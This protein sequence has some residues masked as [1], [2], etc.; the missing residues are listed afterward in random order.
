MNLKNKMFFQ[1]QKTLA[2][3]TYKTIDLY[4]FVK[5]RQF[6][7]QI[8]HDVNSKFRNIN[9]DDYEDD[10]EE[11]LFKKNLNN[12]ESSRE[13][14]NVSDVKFRSD[15]FKSNAN[16]QNLNNREMSQV[17]EFDQ[18]NAFTSYNCDK[19][20]YIA[21]MCRVFRNMNF[22]NFVRKIDEDQTQKKISKR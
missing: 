6:I 11:S 2:L 4:E 9:R 17:L 12:Q 22:K 10:Y 16:N 14:L 1:L 15:T 3:N 13:Q 8:L 18:I 7:D 21:R 19:T 5:L 20:D